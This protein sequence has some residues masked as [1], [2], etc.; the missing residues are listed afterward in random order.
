M[1][2]KDDR[3]EAL[4]TGADRR[5]YYRV[6]V[7]IPLR[8]RRVRPD[9]LE[10]LRIEIRT[11]RVEAEGLDPDLAVRLRT[12][13][14]KLDLVLSYLDD[15]LPAPLGPSDLRAVEIS[16]AG[17]RFDS[18][19]AGAEGQYELLEFQLPSDAASSIRALG[20]IVGCFDP[21]SPGAEPGV[22]LQFDTI[23]E[24]DR[25]AIVRFSNAVQRLDLRARSAERE[26]G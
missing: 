25:E 19:D 22:A 17:M 23:D 26:T 1:A 10:A 11:P 12:I 13:E 5:R 8:H 3:A 6:K 20:R 2:D 15:R 16:G 4:A 24:D 18:K 9:E 7:R 21:A 14:Q